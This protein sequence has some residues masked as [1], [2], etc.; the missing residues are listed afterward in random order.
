MRVVGVHIHVEFSDLQHRDLA[1]TLPGLDAHHHSGLQFSPVHNVF[2]RHP[3]HR[4]GVAQT[5][6]LLRRQRHLQGIA[7]RLSEQLLL[8]RRQDIAMTVQIGDRL[9]GMR[10]LDPDA[11][12]SAQGVMESGNGVLGDMHEWCSAKKGRKYRRCPARHA[13]GRS[14][15]AQEHRDLLAI[16][17][18][19]AR[20]ARHISALLGDA[21][22]DPFE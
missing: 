22:Q 11:V 6:G 12:L 17:V 13:T 2:Q 14:A 5:V 9:A 19:L 1:C 3:L 20:L 4:V 15:P 21:P 7:C 16:V 10:I 8:E 18:E